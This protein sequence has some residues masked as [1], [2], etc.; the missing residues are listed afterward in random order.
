MYKSPCPCGTPPQ[1][2]LLISEK[3]E[4]IEDASNVMLNRFQSVA[5][6]QDVVLDGPV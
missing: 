1:I 3:V 6:S 4:L 2:K 5:H